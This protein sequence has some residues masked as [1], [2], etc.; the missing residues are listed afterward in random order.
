ME[1]VQ[2][3]NNEEDLQYQIKNLRRKIE[4]AD[5]AHKR[6]KN[7]IESWLSLNIFFKLF[8][9]FCQASNYKVY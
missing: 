8:Q 7:F 6:A 3:K 4:I 2:H 1:Y 9:L 5:L